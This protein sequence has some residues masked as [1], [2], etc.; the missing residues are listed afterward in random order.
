[1]S[2]LWLFLLKFALISGS[3]ILIVLVLLQKGK[4]GGLAGAL[5][6]SGGQSAF[7]TKAGDLFTKI[8]MGV[9]IA[10]I[11]VCVIGA[12]AAPSLDTG[13]EG[14][15]IT[16]NPGAGAPQNP[17]QQAPPPASS[18]EKPAGSAAKPEKGA[19]KAP[20]KGPAIPEP[21]SKPSEKLGK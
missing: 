4:G 10:W 15:N 5:G 3:L 16:P 12:M 13:G 6:G 2:W 7:G 21:S 14:L 8:T 20:D 19:E 17:G 9:A 1:M 11:L 18:G